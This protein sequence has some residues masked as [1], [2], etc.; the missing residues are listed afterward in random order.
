M[1]K[2]KTLTINPARKAEAKKLNKL[3]DEGWEIVSQQKR[4]LFEWKPGQVD[5]VLR[6]AD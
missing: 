2:T 4:G 6:K 5:Y 1:S 3:L